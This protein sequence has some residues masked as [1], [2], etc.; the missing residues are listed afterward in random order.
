MLEVTADYQE[1]WSTVHNTPSSSSFTPVVSKERRGWSW[2][3]SSCLCPRSSTL[4]FGRLDCTT[5]ECHQ[6]I[7]VQVVLVVFHLPSS[8]TPMT[9]AV[10]RLAFC[11]YGR[12]AEAFSVAWC[13]SLST[14]TA[15]V[16]WLHCWRCGPAS[17]LAVCVY[18][19]AFQMPTVYADHLSSRSTFLLGVESEIVLY[20]FRLLNKKKKQ[21]ATCSIQ[22]RVN[23]NSLYKMIRWWNCSLPGVRFFWVKVNSWRRLKSYLSSDLDERHIRVSQS[24]GR[25]V[26]RWQKYCVNSCLPW[27]LCCYIALAGVMN[28]CK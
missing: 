17:W 22:C 11:R 10:D 18:N 6:S 19:T 1:L 24:Y 23:I 28:G 8:S 21:N 27:C 20:C 2:I 13:P 25:K 14:P 16:I 12:T 4:L 9:L 15:L 3:F 5:S 26:L 7:S